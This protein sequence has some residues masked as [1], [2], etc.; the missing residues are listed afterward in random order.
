MPLI[1]QKD[2]FFYQNALNDSSFHF[3]DFRDPRNVSSLKRNV[4]SKR[5]EGTQKSAY[6][7][8]TE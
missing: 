7:E 1:R 3:G 2:F 5:H 8:R 6:L 4:N